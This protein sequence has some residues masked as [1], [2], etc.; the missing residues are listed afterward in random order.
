[1]FPDINVSRTCNL[2]VGNTVR[3]VKYKDIF[4]KGY[5][6]NWSKEI[7]TI[8]AVKQKLGVCWYQIADQSGKIYPKLKYYY[9][10]RLIQ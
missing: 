3:V 8:V 1:M 7:F 4:K 10:L 9:A 2:Q 5:T 6:I